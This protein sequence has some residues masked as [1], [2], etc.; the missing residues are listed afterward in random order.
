MNEWSRS[1]TWKFKLKF[2]FWDGI[3]FELSTSAA[4]AAPR[5]VVDCLIQ[6]P[7][8]ET[9]ECLGMAHTIGGLILG[10]FKCLVWCQVAIGLQLQAL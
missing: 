4:A 2:L 10:L 7:Y 8:L 1:S 9:L 5:H 6:N 3:A